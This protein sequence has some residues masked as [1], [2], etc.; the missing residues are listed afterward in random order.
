MLIT[1]PLLSEP[2]IIV[3]KCFPSAPVYGTEWY[4]NLYIKNEGGVQVSHH[5]YVDNLIPS[6]RMIERACKNSNKTSASSKIL[7]VRHIKFGQHASVRNESTSVTIAWALVKRRSTTGI[8]QI[9]AQIPCYNCWRP[10]LSVRFCN[11]SRD[12]VHRTHKLT[13]A[14]VNEDCELKNINQFEL[15][16]IERKAEKAIESFTTSEFVEQ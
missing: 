6:I 10:G 7:Y 5:Q 12:S 14:N 1:S 11:I 8:H 13:L 4:M 9:K 2:I 15:E 3:Q 16:S